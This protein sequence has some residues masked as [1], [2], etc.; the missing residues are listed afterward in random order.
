MS[1]A[2]ARFA[3]RLAKRKATGTYPVRS[4]QGDLLRIGLMAHGQV[5]ELLEAVRQTRRHEACH[6]HSAARSVR[7]EIGVPAERK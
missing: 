3:S 5:V 2:E 6:C 1:K 7:R 4:Q